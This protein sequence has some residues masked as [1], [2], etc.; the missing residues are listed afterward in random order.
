MLLNGIIWTIM[1]NSRSWSTFTL[2]A[3]LTVTNLIYKN[4]FYDQPSDG[5]SIIINAIKLF[6][7]K[8][9]KFG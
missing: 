5:L 9:Y 2:D 6:A 8:N 1:Q 7:K 3:L 4:L